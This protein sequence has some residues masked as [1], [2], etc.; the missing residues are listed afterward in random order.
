MTLGRLCNIYPLSFLLNLGRHRKISYR[1]QHMMVFAGQLEENS[2][3]GTQ[4]NVQWNTALPLTRW[5]VTSLLRPLYSGPNKSLVS[6]FSFTEPLW[7]DHA[8]S[9]A[10]L[11]WPVGERV[12]GVP[13]Y[14]GYVTASCNNISN[15]R[16]SVS[17]GYRNTEK[18]VE[19]T[20]RSGAFLTIFEVFG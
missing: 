8:I 18:R 5:Y 3:S 16:D 20:T 6:H 9:K 1:F 7:Y 13:L 12:N 4:T 15:T 17:S 2:R 11:L 14:C 10:S 19:N